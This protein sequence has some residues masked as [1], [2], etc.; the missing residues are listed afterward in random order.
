MQFIKQFFGAA[1]S[2]ASKSVSVTNQS[3]GC[4][5]VGILGT[6][7][8][9]TDLLVKIQR[10]PFLE[11]VIF[12]GRNVDSEG[13]RYAKNLGVPLS[14]QGIKAFYNEDYACDIVFDAT[15]AAHHLLHAQVFEKLRIF[16]IDMTPSQIG[17]CCVPAL[18]MVDV[19]QH[20][21]VSMI[22]CGGQASIPVAQ[23]L[24]RVI[25][26]ISQ[27]AVKSIVS[28]NSIGPGTLANIDE[29]YQNTKAGLFKYT[30]VG[31]LAVELCVDEIN[32][33]TPMLTSVTAHCSF[34]DM[35]NLIE[36]LNAMLERVRCYVPGYKLVAEPVRLH[37]GVRVDIC[38]EGLG[39]YLPKYA[40][41]L[42]I[43]NCAAIAVAEEYARI[44]L[45]QRQ[46]VPIQ[47]QSDSIFERLVGYRSVG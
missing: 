36:A 20:R 37:D 9:G 18:G 7:K 19:R 23:V 35:D 17:E 47:A 5:R 42:D 12:S 46:F 13:M 10:S 31:D 34:V 3:T 24:S 28:T 43:I 15:S 8:I 6:G 39:D 45:R 33:E 21:N 14:D 1:N 26:N 25:P 22:S 38:V 29:Y 4:L 41:N 16:A 2:S 44:Q 27:I 30:Q 11:C 32:L 40:G